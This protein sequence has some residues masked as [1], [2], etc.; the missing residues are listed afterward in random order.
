MSYDGRSI[1]NFVLDYCE[2]KG[3]PITHL[4][5]QKF[6]YFCHVWYLIEN[7]KPLIKHQFEAWKHGPVLQYLYLDFKGNENSPIQERARKLN[8]V[9]G[10]KDIV[11]YCFSV[12]E[13]D[14]LERAVEFYSRIKPGTLRELSHTAGGPWEVVWNHGGEVN[15]GMKISDKSIADFYSQRKPPF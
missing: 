11:E 8:P 2:S 4:A 10:A 14:F 1:A 13:Q 12:D 15:P 7:R 9:T 5:L 3:R 6:V